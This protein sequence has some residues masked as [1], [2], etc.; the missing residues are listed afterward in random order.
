MKACVSIV[1]DSPEA[2]A[3]AA[4]LAVE[5]G[6]DLVE[7]RF[8]AMRSLPTDLSQFRDIDAPLIA[9][10]RPASQGG[11]YAGGDKERLPFFQSALRAGFEYVDLEQDSVILNVADRALRDAGLIVSH[12]DF[13]GTPRSAEILDILV[14]ES[15]RSD[16]PKAAFHVASI[17]DLLSIID[18]AR[19][20][21]ATGKDC[22]LV[23]MGELGEITRVAHDRID[24]AFTYASLEKGKEAAPGQVDIATMNRLKRDGRIIT[25]VVGASLSHSLSP[26][27]HNAAF[28]DLDL[29]GHY[30]KLTAQA[31]ELEDLLEVAVETEMRGFNV[32]IPHKER[33]IPLLDRLDESAERVRA[34]NTVSLEEGEFVGHNTDVHG[35]EMTFK[36]AGVAPKG[37]KALVV[38]AGGA[39]RAFCAYLSR[40]GASIEITNRT[41]EKAVAL[42]REFKARTV[43]PGEAAQK[44]YD[45]VVNC[46]PLGMKGYPS[47]LPLSAAVF[48]PG[49][50]VMDAIYNPAQTPFLAEAEKRGANVRN[51][52]EMLIRQAMKS[53]EIWTGKVPSYQVMAAAFQE[54]QR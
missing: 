40:Q 21:H 26:P 44:E 30:L 7:I 39:A 49:Q 16:V 5:R 47:E 6:A 29:P 14:N 1:E 35:V 24:T 32:T 25:G 17:Q 19:M 51:G 9:T 11:K 4:G 31:E 50:F 38:G 52:A 18:A 27:M 46:T 37:K 53:F 43:D 41:R 45:I 3:E 13:A 28:R 33:I 8:D 15:A 42:A 10:L 22:V 34:V 2:A 23:G 12:H 20:F 36:N 48:R 54:A